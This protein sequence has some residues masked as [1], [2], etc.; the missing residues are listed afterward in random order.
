MESAKSKR[1]VC[2]VY[3]QSKQDP[4]YLLQNKILKSKLQKVLDIYF[5]FHN[6]Y[7]LE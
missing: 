1:N 3:N 2:N 6:G 5:R 7:Q 4:K